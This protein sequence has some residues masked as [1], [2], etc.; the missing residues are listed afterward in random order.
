MRLFPAPNGGS[1]ESAF[2]VYPRQDIR[3]MPD[4][5]GLMDCAKRRI[6]LGRKGTA[7]LDEVGDGRWTESSWPNGVIE[8]S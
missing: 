6:L 8:T 1:A 2:D 3:R 5:L 4:E 7:S